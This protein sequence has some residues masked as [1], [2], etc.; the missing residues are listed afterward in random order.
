MGITDLPEEGFGLEAS[1][2]VT[3]TGPQV[4]DLKTGD[5]VML[6]SRGSFASQIIT[7]EQLCV[8][9]PDSLS[10]ADAATM[11]CV[12]AT[13]VYSLFTIGG[14]QKGQSVL[15][16]SACGGVGIAAIQ[17]ARMIGADIHVT[18]GNEEK[19][20]YLVDTFRIPRNRIY[21]SRNATFLDG[22]MRETDGRGVDLAL[23]S[24]SGELL[25]T[26]WRCIA[27]FGKMV[28]IGKRDLLGAGK[29]DMDVFLA[30][31]S[32][33]CVDLDQMQSKRR[34]PCKE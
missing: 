21:S 20:Q 5:R 6:F 26:T 31:R 8:R 19:I 32:Y 17:L 14:L 7:S 34:G 18:V 27:E 30:N 4:R 15:I 3:G 2:I 12:Y 9:I 29:L 13:A 25:H 22:V 33:C 28:E 1:G 10:F 16:H 11:P 23:N 24:L